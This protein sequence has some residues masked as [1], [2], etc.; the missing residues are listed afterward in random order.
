MRIIDADA[1]LKCIP[2]EDVNSRFA[3]QN[4]PTIE[5]R[6]KGKWIVIWDR[7]D[8]NTSTYAECSECGKKQL[9]PVGCFCKW[10]G[11]DMRGESE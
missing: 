9:R 7:D 5:E 11:A 6:K 8:S 4:A 10:C 3:V 1:L 2:Y